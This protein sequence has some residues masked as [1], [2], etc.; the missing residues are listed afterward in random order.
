MTT[1][2]LHIVHLHEG[3]TTL[4]AFECGRLPVIGDLSGGRNQIDQVTCEKCK[5]SF[6][7]RE[8]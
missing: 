6:N 2:Q 4:E 3:K 1:K 5:E 7:K 8:A